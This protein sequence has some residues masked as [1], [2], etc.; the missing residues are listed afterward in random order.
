MDGRSGGK[1]R[2][3]FR[4]QSI[5]FAVSALGLIGAPTASAVWSGHS[6]RSEGALF[7]FAL[8][9]PPTSDLEE[10][11]AI[12]ALNESIPA[13]PGL[14]VP[15]KPFVL[16]T[17]FSRAA[18][19]DCLT[20]AIY[21]EAGNEPIKGQRAVA[22]VVLNR[23]R[24]PAFPDSVC[25]VV[26]QGSERRT[27]CQFTF[28]CD[29]S[30]ARRP[31]RSGWIGA[32]TVAIAALSG[33][34]E[35]SVGHA[36]HYHASYVLP[37]W[38]KNLTKLREVGSHIFYQWRGR[39]SQAKAFSD[40]YSGQEAMPVN[41]KIALAGYVL[42]A[43]PGEPGFPPVDLA[44][45]GTSSANLLA[46]PSGQRGEADTTTS[47]KARSLPSGSGLKIE[48]PQLIVTEARL[49]QDPRGSALNGQSAILEN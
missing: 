40:Q 17:S 7:S 26:F 4:R 10:T 19:I 13:N 42:E 45:A 29:G 11:R 18:A 24:H 2:Q 27:G 34:V 14:A 35:P 49:K 3:V 16:S 6:T 43:S 38:A 21:Y 15:A 12:V 44:L 30:L 25:G 5:L 32:Q 20:A 1:E 22:Q 31:S 36:T 8:S 23:M 48:Q 9:Y 39:W 46:A 37:Y 47:P 28:T 41:A 33:L